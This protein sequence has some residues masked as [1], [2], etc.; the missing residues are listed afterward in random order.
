MNEKSLESTGVRRQ[1]RPSPPTPVRKR[2]RWHWFRICLVGLLFISLGTGIGLV[3]MHHAEE[4]AR[5]TMYE[6]S[7]KATTIIREKNTHGNADLSSEHLVGFVTAQLS[8]QIEGASLS[9]SER[10]F[11]EAMH[12][13]SP[14][15]WQEIAR[16]LKSL[17][18]SAITAQQKVIIFSMPLWTE[19]IDRRTA[20]FGSSRQLLH[21]LSMKREAQALIFQGLSTQFKDFSREMADHPQIWRQAMAGPIDFAEKSKTI[22]IVGAEH[23]G[24]RT[25]TSRS[26]EIIDQNLTPPVSE[27]VNALWEIRARLILQA[28]Q[29]Y[30]SEHKVQAVL[31]A[32]DEPTGI[33][34]RHAAHLHGINLETMM[35]TEY[36]Q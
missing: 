28:A 8:R 35:V 9:M 17:T 11:L 19:N 21:Q 1:N 16:D 5:V 4:A 12:A 10:Q 33:I 3:I 26:I 15:A 23:R 27:L 24:L 2:G 32:C 7:R 25:A 14:S 29:K 6:Q 30:L 31:I 18:G 34:I 22:P 36:R 13:I 20:I